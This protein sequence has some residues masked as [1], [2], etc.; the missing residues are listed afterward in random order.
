MELFVTDFLSSIRDIA[1][2][3][4]HIIIS[5]LPVILPII[6]AVFLIVLAIKFF[7]MFH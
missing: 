6:G 5:I 3:A 7:K 4:I 2:S 1:T